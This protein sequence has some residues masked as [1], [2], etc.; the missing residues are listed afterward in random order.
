MTQCKALSHGS[1]RR[2][3]G[4]CVIWL[5]SA[6]CGIALPFLGGPEE[7]PGPVDQTVPEE[8]V[9]VVVVDEPVEAAPAEAVAEPALSWAERT[10]QELTLR[11]KVG[12]LIMPWIL[13]DFAPEGSVSHERVLKYIEEEG[14]GGLIMSVGT[15][16]EVA[17]KLNDLQRH[18]RLPLVVAADL[19][20]GAG[21]RMRGAVYMPGNIELGGAT[22]FPP[23]MAV[24]AVRRRRQH[25]AQSG[26]PVV[27][28]AVTPLGPSRAA[29][30]GMSRRQAPSPTRTAYHLFRRS[31]LGRPWGWPRRP[32]KQGNGATCATV[33]PY[34]N[35]GWWPGAKTAPRHY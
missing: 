28:R 23:L 16:I 34:A 33:S 10:L 4:V 6:A 20:T 35:S 9:V 7:P 32:S 2:G 14:I 30:G 18:S 24:G 15:P 27:S 5:G 29:S 22:N 13:G 31:T 8:A 12:Q 21:F 19:E 11:E 17:A 25:R 1:L 26:T 3:L